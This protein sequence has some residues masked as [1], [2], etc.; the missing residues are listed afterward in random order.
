MFDH[1]NFQYKFEIG[2]HRITCVLTQK[3]KQLT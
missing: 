1:K 2:L 3:A